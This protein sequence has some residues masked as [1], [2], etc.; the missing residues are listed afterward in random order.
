MF[1]WHAIPFARAL[2]PF[3]TGIMVCQYAPSGTGI[4]AAGLILLLLLLVFF[5][6]LFT[7]KSHFRLRVM[8]GILLS[9]CILTLGYLRTF[10]HSETRQDRHFASFSK[11]KFYH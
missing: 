2:I 9:L 1:S 5:K 10:W 6:T 3:I 4:P 11:T 8:Q 7:Q